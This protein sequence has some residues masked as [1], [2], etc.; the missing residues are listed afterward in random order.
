MLSFMVD[1]V[2]KRRQFDGIHHSR[3][4]C[5]AAG[6]GMTVRSVVTLQEKKSSWK[7]SWRAKAAARKHSL[8]RKAGREGEVGIDDGKDLLEVWECL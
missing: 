3:R 8:R 6:Q 1:S 4:M 2:G 7:V 5:H